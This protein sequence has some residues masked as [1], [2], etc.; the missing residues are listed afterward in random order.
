MLGPF[1]LVALAALLGT[2]AC[3]EMST[4]GEPEPPMGEDEDIGDPTE[5]EGIEIGPD[6]IDN[7]K[8]VEPGPAELEVGSPQA[9][10]EPR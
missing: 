9:I 2:C 1:R 10:P 6:R 4:R 3:A 7:A 8:A 5:I